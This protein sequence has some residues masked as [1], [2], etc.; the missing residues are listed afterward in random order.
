MYS[1]LQCLGLSL[2]LLVN[3]FASWFS[4]FPHFP[5]QLW[6]QATSSPGSDRTDCDAHQLCAVSTTPALGAVPSFSGSL[7]TSCCSLFLSSECCH[8]TDDY[9]KPLSVPGHCQVLTGA[10]TGQ[11][12]R[13]GVGTINTLLYTS[14]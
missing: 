3:L 13:P 14:L 7:H 6:Y 4:F 1:F 5:L 12:P 10:L 2:P 9:K 11:E 8:S